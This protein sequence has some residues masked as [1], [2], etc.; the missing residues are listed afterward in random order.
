MTE[1]K[2]REKKFGVIIGG[3]GLVGGGID[4]YF[5][6]K[7]GYDILAPN[8]KK[9]S[10]RDPKDIEEYFRDHPPD[11]IVNCAIAALDSDPKISFEINYIGAINLAK[12]AA[13]LGIPYIF[14]SSAAV[15]PDGNKLHED[16]QRPL[17][18]DLGNYAKSKL[19]S[20]LTLQ[21]L[22]E[23]EGLDY[24]I[25]RLAIVY[26]KHDHKI[27]GFHRLLFS[28][29]EQSM[30]LLFTKKEVYH[31]Y[32]NAKKLPYFIRHVLAK[33][34]EFSGQAY[35]FVDPEPVALD[36]L[37]LTI[38]DILQLKRP[39][40][41]YL[42]LPVARFGAKCVEQFLRLLVKLG[43]DARLP[44]ELMFLNQFYQTQVLSSEKLRSSSFIDPHPEQTVYSQLPDLIQYY[45]TRWEQLNLINPFN[46]EFFDPQLLAEEFLNKPE[47]LLADI[48][49]KKIEPFQVFIDEVNK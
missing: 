35:H 26:G 3:S 34:Q 25:I 6:K 32:S 8:S 19:M 14:I 43:I 42:P 9:L 40:A 20:E 18:A 21:H 5:K 27:Q 2:N 36:R 17:S 46:E 30:P 13:A 12:V 11:F 23:T 29:A 1:K 4:Y 44:Q 7:W 49:S 48:H 10:I 31:S 16:D 15:L 33:R 24:T 37:I 45:L 38:R 41:I 47:S 39:K 28:I 22:R